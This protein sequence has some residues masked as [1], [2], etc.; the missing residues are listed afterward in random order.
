M[1]SAMKST[2]CVTKFSNPTTREGYFTDM[3]RAAV[4]PETVE[5]QWDLNGLRS[6]L[7]NG[8]GID[9]DFQ[10]MLDERDDITDEDLLKE[11]IDRVN[12]IYHAKEELVG[13]EPF[14]NLARAVLI[15]ML[16]QLWRQHISSL[17][18]LRQG[19]Y[20]RGYAQ[21]Q[22]KQEYK[23]EAFNMFEA[24]LDQIRESV[25]SYLM[26]LEIRF[27]EDEAQNP[28]GGAAAETAAEAPSEEA[29]PQISQGNGTNSEEEID[30]AVFAHCG[31]NDP[32][33][34]GSGLR[35]KDCHGKL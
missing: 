17:D 35:F 21:K 30:P 12:E 4:P 8:F 25:V 9:I 27:T 26:R 18:A 15:G 13:H 24:L 14:N 34:C 3:F 1:T 5:E 33:P 7:Q 31:R 11:I 19:I 16:D 6:Q 23:R 32:C 10:K 28:Q 22:P 20:L 2:A 29:T